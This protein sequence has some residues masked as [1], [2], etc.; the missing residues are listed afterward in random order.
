MLH[1]INT[2]IFDK[3]GFLFTHN[4]NFKKIVGDF[5]KPHY[6]MINNAVFL[7]DIALKTFPACVTHSELI[8][9]KISKCLLIF[10]VMAYMEMFG[11]CN[12]SPQS[13]SEF[14]RHSVHAYDAEHQ[15]S[16]G[17]FVSSA[18]LQH[19]SSATLGLNNNLNGQTLMGC[20][21]QLTQSHTLH[22]FSI[23][24]GSGS[25]NQQNVRLENLFYFIRS[26]L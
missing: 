18:Q 2:F 3:F 23:T 6:P 21:Q 7:F 20:N 17:R 9:N 26:V 8:L 1:P 25:C 19:M 24:A 10:A 13:S 22:Q 14:L 12:H 15:H 4:I 16:T 11:N 5:G